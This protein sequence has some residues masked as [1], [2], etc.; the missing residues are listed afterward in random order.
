MYLYQVGFIGKRE[1]LKHPDVTKVK[2][3]AEETPLQVLFK[4]HYIYLRHLKEIC[5]QLYKILAKKYRDDYQL[6]VAEIELYFHNSVR[7]IC[8]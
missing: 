4:S 3:N 7:F 2:N 8:D 5:P 6:E 1:V